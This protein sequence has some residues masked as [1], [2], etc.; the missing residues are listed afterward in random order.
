MLFVQNNSTDAAEISKAALHF[1]QNISLSPLV[2]AGVLFFLGFLTTCCDRMHAKQQQQRALRGQSTKVIHNWLLPLALGL[3]W[4]ATVLTFVTAVATTETVNAMKYVSTLQSSHE[5]ITPGTP[6]QA[7]QWVTFALLLLFTLGL[8][9]MNYGGVIGKSAGQSGG[10]P[11]SES[12]PSVTSKPT[13][14][15]SIKIPAVD[16]PS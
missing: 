10:L 7:I 6:L 14:P 3:Y 8:T 16:P 1:Q 5:P 4:L 2:A 9:M 11:K 13:Q 15:T 12:Q